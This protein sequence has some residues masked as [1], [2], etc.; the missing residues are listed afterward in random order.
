MVRL[1]AELAKSMDKVNP[2]TKES[3]TKDDVFEQIIKMYLV[4]QAPLYG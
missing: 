3:V 2:V 1:L 4:L